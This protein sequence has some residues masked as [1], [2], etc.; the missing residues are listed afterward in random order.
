MISQ[1]PTMTRCRR[2][3]TTPSRPLINSKVHSF[4]SFPYHVLFVYVM[5]SGGGWAAARSEQRAVSINGRVHGFYGVTQRE[6][7]GSWAGSVDLPAYCPGCIRGAGFA[8]YEGGDGGFAGG[9]CDALDS[10]LCVISEGGVSYCVYSFVR[11]G[12]QC[13]AFWSFPPL[14]FPF[15]RQGAI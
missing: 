12:F 6:M 10:G 2:H 8:L 4:P 15:P 14:L 7:D 9:S 5:G 11:R 13:C 3:H 1:T